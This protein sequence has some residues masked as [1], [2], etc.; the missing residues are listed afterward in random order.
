MGGLGLELA[1]CAYRFHYRRSWARGRCASAHTCWAFAIEQQGLLN[2]CTVAGY[3]AVRAQKTHATGT[4]HCALSSIGIHLAFAVHV[5]SL[6]VPPGATHDK[7]A[8]ALRCIRSITDAR[9]EVCT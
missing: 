1:P 4:T 7:R 8:K 3:R 5:P 6:P 2:F 9:A